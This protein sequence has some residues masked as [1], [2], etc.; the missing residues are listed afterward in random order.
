MQQKLKPLQSEIPDELVAEISTLYD[1][2]LEPY[3]VEY[4]LSQKQKRRG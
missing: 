2:G 4:L 1:L 3:E